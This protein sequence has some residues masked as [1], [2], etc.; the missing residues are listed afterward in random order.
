MI[1]SPNSGVLT[2]EL[3]DLPVAE[4]QLA[5]CFTG[6]NGGLRNRLGFET[7]LRWR[8]HMRWL[9][10]ARFG[11]LSWMCWRL[12]GGGRGSVVRNILLILLSRR[13]LLR[14]CRLGRLR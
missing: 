2:G 3:H 4:C 9:L 5:P 11:L 13:G 14:L 1:G 8:R 7:R 10:D 12:R 6:S